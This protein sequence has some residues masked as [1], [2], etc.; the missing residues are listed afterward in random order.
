MNFLVSKNFLTPFHIDVDSYK[1]PS[2]PPTA[3]M[4]SVRDRHSPKNKF[5]E[6]TD[7]FSWAVVTFQLYMGTHPYKGR[8]DAYKPKDWLKMM[9]DNVSVFHKDV[10]LPANCQDWS[11]IPKPHFEWYKRV[12][13]NKERSIPPWPDEPLVIAIT[14]A[15]VIS[16]TEKF[17]I[18][19]I[20]DYSRNIRRI[21]FFDGIR[22]AVLD[23]EI[24][25]NDTPVFAFN[26]KENAFLCQATGS[27]PV[28]VYFEEK[29]AEFHAD[30]TIIG[31]IS[32]KSVMELNGNVYTVHNGTLTENSCTVF[33]IKTVHHTKKVCDIFEPAYKMFRGMV[34]QDIMGHC[35]AAIPYK[36]G[37]CAN[38]HIPE[39]DGYR[40]IDAKFE[41]ENNR[42]FCVIMAERGGNYSRFTL[43]F[44]AQDFEKYSI[45][46]ED[47]TELDEVNFTVLSNGVCV[48][49]VR[50]LRI[51]IF[52]DNNKVKEV[53]GPPLDSSMPLFH[54][55]TKVLFANGKKLYRIGLK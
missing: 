4:E 17:E 3:L 10:R 12:F 25:K 7:W 41:M 6:L 33:G 11:V 28:P 55:G 26:R 30:G 2:F 38:F 40:V 32:A 23:G 37:T 43:C 54:D 52:V 47:N 48:M 1:T 39:L 9:D 16:G 35:W 14:K 13:V 36:A 49:A 45:R 18:D 21:Q 31:R 8:H 42:G 46:I 27:N 44:Q 22:Y 24:L 53:E 15:V 50:D 34:I 20:K 19:L 51:E 29:S 5:S